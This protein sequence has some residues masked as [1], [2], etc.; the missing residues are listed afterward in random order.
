MSEAFRQPLAVLLCQL[1]AVIGMAA[2][3][4]RLFKKMGQPSVIGE[5]AA[6]ILLGP[7][8]LGRAWP[9]AEQFLFPKSSLGNLG[10]LSQVGVLLFM[11]AVGLELDLPGLRGRARTAVTVSYGGI[12]PPFA[13][14]MG[15]AYLLYHAYA[16]AGIRLLSFSLFM[17]IA[18]SITAFPVLARILEERNLS[19]TPMGSTALASAAVEDVTAWTLLALVVA[20][21]KAQSP[22]SAARV[23]ALALLFTL[24]M[25]FGVRRAAARWARI[26]VGESAPG[27][28]LV[29]VILIGAFLSALA[30]ETIGI[31]ALFGAFL[32]GAILPKEKKLTA[33]LRDRL[34]YSASLYLLPIFFASTGL[35]TQLGL[36]DQ[37]RDWFIF[38]GILA[39]AVGGK[40]GG[41]CLAARLGG[42][43]WRDSMALG[44]LMNTRGLMELIVLNL[45]LD[46]GIL[47]PRIFAMMVLMALTT[48][49]M[50]G[51]LLTLLGLGNAA[52]APANDGARKAGKA[53][54]T[55]A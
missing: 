8:V 47:S 29:A 42:M 3:C 33:F 50:T 22:A 36:L 11:F 27:K 16:P 28:G 49:A 9:G 43:G 6:G 52:P 46:L 53:G 10:L 23:A 21:A 7:S 15:L 17:G 41:V 4:G 55:A 54:V 26:P 20:V 13:L 18:M 5:M 38:A 2:L 37:G 12:L 44:S 31:H 51:P 32:A 19:G 1:A 39:V 34:E 35:R 45:G 14:G 48:T 25:V 24:A 40:L 30:T